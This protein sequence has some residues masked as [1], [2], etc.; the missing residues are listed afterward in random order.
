MPIAF[1]FPKLD[2][3]I[4]QATITAWLRREGDTVAAGEMVVEMAT[5][6]GTLETEAPASGTLLKILAPE[7]STLP[8]GYIIAWIG[9]PGDELPDATAENE[10]ILAEFQRHSAG[11]GTGGRDRQAAGRGAERVR[12]R[13]TP[14]ARRIARER[15]LDLGE[16]A[17]RLGVE[18]ITEE[19]LD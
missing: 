10:A 2:A 15:G 8:V 6:K 14:A 17:A 4:E 1:R 16:I 3:N 5:D 9:Q 11:T 13:A 12:V 18:T 19:M 7:N